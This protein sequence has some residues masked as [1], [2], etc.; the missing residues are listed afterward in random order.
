MTILNVS[1]LV[2]ATLGILFIILYRV[3]PVQMDAVFCL[4]CYTEPSNSSMVNKDYILGPVFWGIT[5]PLL[6]V[7]GI[8]FLVLL[9]IRFILELFL[10]GKKI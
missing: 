10:I 5:W 1:L 6:L 7:L 2:Y 3:I 4:D 9:S 8:I